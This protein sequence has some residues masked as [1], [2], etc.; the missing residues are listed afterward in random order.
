MI[1]KIHESYRK[2]VALCDSELLGK[3]FEE[4]I[5][6]L[7]VREDFY[8]K[9]EKEETEIIQILQD[10]LTEDATF[11]FVG[12]RAVEAGIK[13]GVISRDGI[14]ETAGIPYALSLM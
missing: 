12:K 1:I 8:G 3:K 13:A 5:K 10:A 2:I 4:G 7:D 14:L 6:Q 9:E 11:N